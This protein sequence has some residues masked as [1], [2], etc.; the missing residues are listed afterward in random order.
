VI[1]VKTMAPSVPLGM[2]SDGSF[3][4]PDKLAP[5]TI[6]V[7]AVKKTPNTSMKLD[8]ASGFEFIGPAVYCAHKLVLA[9]SRLQPVY[10]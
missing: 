6:P 1:N 5:A 7:T 10:P 3:K 4:S 2:A 9:V 8:S